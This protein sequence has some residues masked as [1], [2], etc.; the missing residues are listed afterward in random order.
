MDENSIIRVFPKINSKN[1]T[2]QVCD[3]YLKNKWYTTARYEPI[4]ASF[5]EVWSINGFDRSWRF[6]HH[7][8][9]CIPILLD[10][11]S[12]KKSEDYLKHAKRVIFHWFENNYP[13]S[14]S[15]MGWH[16]HSTAWRLINICRFFLVWKSQ[17]IDRSHDDYKQLVYI[18]KIHVGKLLDENFYRP[19]HNH[20]LDQ[21]MAI[22]T[23]A[24]I[25]WQLPEAK[26][27][28]RVA[29][30]R[31]WKQVEHLFA[32]DGSYLEHSPHYV[33][34]ILNNLYSFLHFLFDCKHRDAIKLQKKLEECLVFLIYVLRADGVIPPIGDSEQLILNQMINNIKKWQIKSG[35][36][37]SFFENLLINPH[38]ERLDKESEMPV[39]KVFEDGGF[40]CLRNKW[41][42]DS[43]TIQALFYSGF[44]SRV[45][46]HHD[47]LSFILFH[48][49]LPLITE[50]G[51]Y[52]YEYSSP[53][54]QY[55]VSP[56]VHNSIMVDNSFTDISRKNIGKSGIDSYFFNETISYISASH[57]LYKD[58]THR[59]LFIWLKP[60]KFLI[61]DILKGYKN[62][63]V[64]TFF[65][66]N[67]KIKCFKSEGA[68]VGAYQNDKVVKVRHVFTN[69]K[70]KKAKL[71]KGEKNPL[72]GWVS[73]S[74]SNL[75]PN[76]LLNFRSAGKTVKN[77]FDI[78]I[79]EAIDEE[80]PKINWDK[81]RIIIHYKNEIIEIDTFNSSK[82]IKINDLKFAIKKVNNL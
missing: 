2:I 3:D 65:N 36:L 54:R 33:Y 71:Y 80:S 14:P 1:K 4:E 61:A 6:Q 47:D 56:Y 81:E 24:I 52:S 37:R 27:W 49:H 66:L 8:L 78:S 46:K 22:F 48:N 50:G 35:K 41:S 72:K 7:G 77:V 64:D 73:P 34:L 16:D 15:D 55:I 31:F 59:R 67:H 25:L 12:L 38:S 62:H 68:Y 60:H 19:K 79:G 28:E 75:R 20:G 74:Y 32:E 69:S 76:P 9:P 58:I 63:K 23:A 44:H 45:H 11:Y 43:D 17:Y 5:E 29:I 10:G 51:K 30:N 21:D 70:I 42:Y 57:N 18:I 82:N 26:E 53:E 39:E 40:A 13:E